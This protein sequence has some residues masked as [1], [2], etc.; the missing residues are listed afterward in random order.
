MSISE[1][2][3]EAK[4]AS[5]QLSAARTEVKNAALEAIANTLRQRCDQITAVNEV[6]LEAAEKNNLAGPLLKRLKFDVDK[7]GDVCAGIE[8]LIKINDPVGEIMAATELDEGLKLYKVSCPIG[9]IGVVFESRPDALV[10]ISSLCLKSGNAV[11][12]KGGSEAKKTNNIL[13]KIICEASEK[14]GV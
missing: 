12:L 5:I 14:S 10:Q 4:A 7:I 8:D 9:V 6:D 13:S 2:A 1:M 3:A 11:L